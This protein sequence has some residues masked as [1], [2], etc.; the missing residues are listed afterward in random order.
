M[1]IYI[2][3]YIYTHIQAERERVE[4]VEAN[5]FRNLIFFFI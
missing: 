3:I 1:Y 5:K 4:Q 2:Y